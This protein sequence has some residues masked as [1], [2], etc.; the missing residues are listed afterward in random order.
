MAAYLGPGGAR[1]LAAL[2]QAFDPQDIMNPGKLTPMDEGRRVSKP[3]R[4]TVASRRTRAP[5]NI[6]RFQRDKFDIAI[7]GGGITGAGIARDAA[8]RGL[9]VALL[10]KGDFGSGTSSKSSRMIHGGLRYLRQRHVSL[11]RE[12]LRERGV[13]LKI[14]PHL[15]RPFPFLLP[16]YG[17]GLRSV[18]SSGS[19]SPPTISWPAGAGSSATACSPAARCCSRSPLCARTASRAPSVYF[20]CLVHDARLTLATARSAARQGAAVANYVQATGLER[21]DQRPDGRRGRIVGVHFRDLLSGR[22]NLLR[23]AI[24]VNAAGPWC[25]ELR[26]MTNL[27]PM[28]RP[29][30][31]V[32]VVLPHQRLPVTNVVI[33]FHDDRGLFAVPKDDWTYVG[34]TDTDY[35]GD[36]GQARVDA[37]DVAYVLEASNAAFPGASLRAVGHHLVLG[38]RPAARGRGRRPHSLGRLARLR[39][40]ERTAGPDIHRRRQAHHLSLDGPGLAG[41]PRGRRRTAARLVGAPLLH[42]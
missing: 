22:S 4:L 14:A 15:V 29:T 34:T 32:H 33:F 25:D 27:P 16:V 37:A 35:R 26:A 23:A 38:R 6:E 7:I 28:L 39:D 30:K 24:V 1:A 8:L 3:S 17:S 10:E 21:E 13:L 41:P 11:V 5:T 36:P 9:S 31:G 18:S 2:K 40:R 12:S 19:A 20:D 42:S